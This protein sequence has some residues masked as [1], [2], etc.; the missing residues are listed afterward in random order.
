MSGRF[1]WPLVLALAL[2][3]LVAWG[4]FYYAFAILMTP[5]ATEFGWSKP[6]M[7]GALS[8]GL[9][10]TGL[11]SFGIGRRID[12]HGGRVLMTVGALFGAVLLVLWSQ[13]TALWQLYVLWVGIG[14]VCATILYDPV[15]AVVARAFAADYRRAI[16][17]IT[18]LGGLASTVFIPATQAL[19][20]F[21]GWRHALLGL[22]LIELP[23]CAGIPWILLRGR[24]TAVAATAVSTESRSVG[25]VARAMRQPVYW[26]LVA[27]FIS[28][29]LFY[30]ALLFNLVPLLRERGFTT[31]QAVA[32]Y[33]CIGPSQVAG[34]IVLLTLERWLTATIAGIVATALPVAALVI[35]GA[36]APDSLSVYV[37]AVAFG[38][39]MGIKTI[40][41]ATAAP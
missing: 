32:V 23:I 31:G 14:A 15:F 33:A 11:A 3:Q 24:E 8:L 40:V 6:A 41:Q 26:L 9:A 17:T 36:T 25:I 4:T 38:A 27:S 10:V 39:G 19:V 12:R 34:R 18:L 22:A 1:P 16:T 21:F 13:I 30:T 20:A 29:A 37:F 35:L 28:F 2:A 7:N 5:M